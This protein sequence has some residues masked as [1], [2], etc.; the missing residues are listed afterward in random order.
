MITN[1]KL[2]LI[3]VYLVPIVVI[4]FVLKDE[5]NF[6]LD[7]KIFNNER[8]SK[9]EG[10]DND[11]EI[12]IRV[13]INNNVE[14]IPLEE[15]I[16]GV[17]A[18]EMP[19]SFDSEALKAQAVASRS[20][21]LHKKKLGRGSYDVT[22]DV[23]S[24]VYVSLDTMKSMWGSSFDKYYEKIK[25]AVMDTKGK[26]ITY[27][28]N[29]IDALYFAMSDGMTQ[30]VTA[31]FS[32][33]LAYLKSVPSEYDNSS[34][35]DFESTRAFDHTTL[36]NRLGLTCS[37][38]VVNSISYNDAEYVDRVVIC[39]K[40]FSGEQ[41]RNTLGLRSASFKIDISESIV[42]TTYGYGHGVGMSQ[43][44]ANGYAENGY[45]YED[46]IKHYYKNVEITDIK[47][48]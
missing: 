22:A 15:Y 24:Q 28:G 14:S 4:S 39:D 20:Y 23:N 40:T 2:F 18:G 5:T 17:V 38:I 1:K 42:I 10:N 13:L 9:I 34:I 27:N 12:T 6:N 3:A 43:Y 47:N 44:G 48:V 21:A 45:S 33:N 8:I 32:E 30:D 46:I 26:V 31:V 25:K 7:E 35:R 19:A 37:K 36:A 11:T 16:I 29:V 41:I